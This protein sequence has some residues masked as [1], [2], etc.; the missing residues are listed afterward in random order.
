MVLELVLTDWRIDLDAEITKLKS[1]SLDSVTGVGTVMSTMSDLGMASPKSEVTFQLSLSTGIN[2]SEAQIVLKK[3]KGK[4]KNAIIMTN[5]KVSYDESI[6]LI[7]KYNGNLR[8][9]LRSD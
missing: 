7:S 9:I 6:K 1:G 4:V 8:L 5:L 2:N 3:S